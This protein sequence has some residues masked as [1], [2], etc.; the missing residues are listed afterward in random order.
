M[1]ASSGIGRCIAEILLA[2]GWTLGLAARRSELLEDFVQKGPGRVHI[3]R[4]DVNAD[5]SDVR[6]LQLAD[7]IGGMDVYIHCAGIGWQNPELDAEKELQTM[8]TNAL[9]FC[10]MVGA[11]FRYFAERSEGHI[12]AISSIAG[13]RGLGQAPAYSASK[14]MQ[15]T[16]LEAL[17]QLAHMR[18]L[19][20]TI[21]DVRPG[22]VRTPLLGDH[23]KFPMLM[24]AH[25]VARQIVRAISARKRVVVVDGRWR[26]LTALWSFVPHAVWRRLKI[27]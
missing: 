7:V 25:D 3:C 2:E 23:P 24:D 21:T 20:I 9:G 19:G 10:R 16:Y 4:I 26:V 27:R 13:T 17:T 8:Q 14:A 18:G 11:A 12:V 1:G 6:L 15:N 22:F 5:D